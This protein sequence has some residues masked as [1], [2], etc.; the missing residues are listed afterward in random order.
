[1]T[2]ARRL[3]FRTPADVEYLS[4][5]PRLRQSFEEVLPEL[6]RQP[7]RSGLGYKVS[8]VG[9]HPGLWKLKLADLPPRV[10]RAVYE[11]DGETLRFLGFGPR[12]DFYRKLRQKDRLSP[13]RF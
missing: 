13:S 4:L 2:V 8:A 9:G 7:F 10:F 12:L 5:A 11:V 1:M 3:V 6:L